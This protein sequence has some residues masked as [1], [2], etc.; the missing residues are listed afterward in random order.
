MLHASGLRESDLESVIPRAANST[1]MILRGKLK[2]TT[3]HMLQVRSCPVCL[4]RIPLCSTSAMFS[5][6]DLFSRTPLTRITLYD[7]IIH[8]H[9]LVSTHIFGNYYIFYSQS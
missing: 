6:L 8:E 7:G 4:G 1:V 2:H 9:G 3:A 5:A